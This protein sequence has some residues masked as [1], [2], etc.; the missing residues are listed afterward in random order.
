[1]KFEGGFGGAGLVHASEGLRL[2][3]EAEQREF[4]RESAR[5]E[6]QRR[7][8][9]E[10]RRER[11]IAASVWA[12]ED[13]GEF[14]SARDRAQGVGRTRAEAVSYYSALADLE[15]AKI[16]HERQ[17]AFANFEVFMA[18]RESADRTMQTSADKLRTKIDRFRER[19]GR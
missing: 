16:A 10:A 9:A 4:E 15:D 11:D 14:V 17:K 8:E 6:E 18:E 5:V 2:R 3:C 12:A 13:R 19:Y 7:Q 1:M